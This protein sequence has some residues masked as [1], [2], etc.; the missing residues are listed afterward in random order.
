[1]NAK[2]K[3]TENLQILKCTLD[4]RPVARRSDLYEIEI[5]G[6]V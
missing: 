4:A 6:L 3:S 1:M 2:Y 5:Q